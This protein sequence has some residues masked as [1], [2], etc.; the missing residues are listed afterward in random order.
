MRRALPLLLIPLCASHC[1]L[2]L[3]LWSWD[4]V[5]K[6][7]T[8]YGLEGPGI[9]SWW[10]EIFRTYP[11]RLQGPPS[12]L[13][14]GY[15]GFP[16]G[17]G[18]RGVMLTTHSLLVPRLRKRWAI[19]PLT[20]WVL[21]GLLHG[22][23]YL[24]IPLYHLL[25]F[26]LTIFFFQALDTVWIFNIKERG[27]N[28]NT[29]ILYGIKY[30]HKTYGNLSLFKNQNFPI[31]TWD[32]NLSPKMMIYPRMPI[33]VRSQMSCAHHSTNVDVHQCTKISN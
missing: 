26:N 33:V 15:W 25:Q 1:I 9:E 31:R 6:I 4:S 10:G 3:P 18:G 5:V 2:Y 12:L 28:T 23:L 32:W 16:G 27:I 11:D 30:I 7:A 20:P 13:Y 29:Q 8:H 22:Y 14:K 24:Y 19:P 21:L 17:K